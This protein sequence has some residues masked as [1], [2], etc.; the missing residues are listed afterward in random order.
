MQKK[1]QLEDFFLKIFKVAI[2]VLMTLAILVMVALLG[3]AAYETTK[4]PKEPAPAQK[5]QQREITLEDLKKELLKEAEPAPSP[6]Q[7]QPRVPT[8]LRYLEDVTRVYRCSS[9]FAKKVNA[10]IDETDNSVIARRVEDLRSQIERLADEKKERGDRWVKS[11]VE[12]TCTALADPSIIAMRKEGKVK[13]VF[14]P[15]LNYHLQRWDAIE[16]EKIA[17]EQSELARVERERQ[18]EEQRIAEAKATALAQLIAAGIAFGVFMALALYL[19]LAKIESNL[20]NIN[21]T[22]A[23][24]KGDEPQERL[25]VESL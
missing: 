25:A 7:Q 23:A 4:R 10:E 11:A 15:I 19:I 18:A 3:S 13:S 1:F 20:R 5:A 24:F 6:V 8:T 2:L 22:I 12:F 14:F 17:F 21:T 9:E 16:E